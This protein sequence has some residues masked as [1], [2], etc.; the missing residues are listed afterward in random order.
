MRVSRR[1]VT[2]GSSAKSSSQKAAT[3]LSLVNMMWPPA[4]SP[5]KP[6]TTRERHRP[7]ISPAASRTVTSWP[8][9][10]SRRAAIRPEGPPPTTA[11][12]AAAARGRLSIRGILPAATRLY[13]P[14]TGPAP[15]PRVTAPAPAASPG[16]EETRM[17]MLLPLLLAATLIVPA[18]PPAAPECTAT[19]TLP[20]SAQKLELRWRQ[21][22]DEP[23]YHESE[24]L[25][26]KDLH[27]LR[28][29]CLLAQGAQLRTDVPVRVGEL[30]LAPGTRPLGFT[31]ALGGA[32]HLFV[33]DGERAV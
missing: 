13:N 33:G 29:Q 2:Q 4:T 24:G 5:V 32:P 26:A 28:V 19:L 6:S 1:L 11:M 12:R 16:R 7:P 15:R 21:L 25:D 31:V 22:P 10:A 14:A 17:K 3:R 9:C 20:D 18:P 30:L 23:A 27:A 8:S